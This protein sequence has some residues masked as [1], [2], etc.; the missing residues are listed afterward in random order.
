M[1]QGSRACVAL[2][3]CENFVLATLIV[4]PDHSG[5]DFFGFLDSVVASGPRMLCWT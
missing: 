4:S 3:F 2:V 1:V 5:W